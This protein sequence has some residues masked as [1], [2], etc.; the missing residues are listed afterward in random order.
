M[1]DKSDRPTMPPAFDVE[2]YA[3]ESDARIGTVLPVLPDEEPEPGPDTPPATPCSEVRLMTRPDMGAV[4]TDETWAR[5]VTGA[6]VVVM[7][8]DAL[9]RLPLDHR[10]GFLLS[11]MDGAI[12]LDTLA[13]I[14]AMPRVEVLRVVRDLFE[15]GV[16]EFR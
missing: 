7:A 9:K 11:M 10:A 2:R 4:A 13:E 8:A 12:D 5:S 16:V 3:K 6:P 1:P 15:S 14:A